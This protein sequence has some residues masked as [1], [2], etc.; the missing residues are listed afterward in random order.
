[1]I[2]TTPGPSDQER[3]DQVA[4]GLRQAADLIQQHPALLIGL[5][6]Q[7]VIGKFVYAP[8]GGSERDVLTAFAAALLAAGESPEEYRAGDRAGI[9]VTVGAV[10]I[11]AWTLV[12]C[13][14]EP[15]PVAP[16]PVYRPLLPDLP[17][18]AEAW[19]ENELDHD[20]VPTT[21][22]YE[23]YL[24]SRVTDGHHEDTFGG[25]R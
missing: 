11:N 21:A 4:A 6:E 19:G 18:S 7:P 22:G 17:M 1:M 24:S 9:K 12:H 15:R 23:E 10:A 14:A 5:D 25:P 13:L 16:Q 3:A 20:R 8:A 2:S